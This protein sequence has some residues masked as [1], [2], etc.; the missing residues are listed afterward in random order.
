MAGRTGW[1][2]DWHQSKRVVLRPRILMLRN[3]QPARVAPLRLAMAGMIGMAAAMGIGRFVYTPILPGMMERAGL[4]R[5]RCRADRIGQL[6]RLSR[7]RAGCRRRLGDGRERRPLML[8]GLAA[9][10]LLAGGDG[11]D[12][13]R[14]RRSWRSASSPA[15]PAPS[16][17]SSS[18][19]SSSA[20]SPR[21]TQRSPGAA[22]RR[23][24]P[25]HRGVVG[26]DGRS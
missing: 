13:E 18:Q 9:S 8:A 10:A 12:R 26:D 5:G 17:W 1:L 7:R 20:I 16:S 19:A 15:S 21:Q 14:S 11:R 22:F 4:V 24:R 6:S 3:A 2:R 23:R 25:R